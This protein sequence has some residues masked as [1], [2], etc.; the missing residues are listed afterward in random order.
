[1]GLLITGA[2]GGPAPFERAGLIPGPVAWDPALRLVRE[3]TL[4]P[5]AYHP[6]S[7]L[8]PLLVNGEYARF[9]VIAVAAL[10]L[11]EVEISL[12]ALTSRHAQL[13][14]SRGRARC[15]GSGHWIWTAP[16]RPGF[17]PAAVLLSGIAR[18]MRLQMLV[19]HPASWIR[20]GA[21][22]NYPI[23]RYN[24]VPLHGDPAYIP[25]IGYV[26]V[27]QGDEDIR[28]SPHFSA[29]QFLC[30]QGG[31]PNYFAY[32]AAL[33]NKLEAALQAVNDSGFT[34]ATFQL[35]SGFRTPA[36]NARIGNE[37]EYSR[38]LWGDA[39]DFLVDSDGDGIMDDL[40]HDGR[41]D[42]ED[43]RRLLEIVEGVERCRPDVSRGGIGLY[44]P[45]PEHGPFV[46][47]DTRGHAARW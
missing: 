36:Y 9:E 43:S 31:H 3:P 13:R 24:P 41:I 47:L 20:K 4:P 35:I 28:L 15:L 19:L 22:H 21:L 25:P 33:V 26:E 44:A 37:T 16:S 27:C 32:S 12:P 17:V 2:A 23:G 30:K 38:H 34:V 14:F 7:A 29:G 5:R 18:P 10:P 46:H 11:G 6:D 1:M 42:M 40:N 8:F 39:A 45:T